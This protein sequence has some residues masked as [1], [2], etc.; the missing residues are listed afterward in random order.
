MDYERIGLAVAEMLDVGYT[1]EW[2]GYLMNIYGVPERYPRPNGS[3]SK[4]LFA[5]D[6]FR[7][8]AANEATRDIIVAIAD[9]IIQSERFDPRNKKAGERHLPVFKS[10]LER[11]GYRFP[12]DV[13]MR[14]VPYFRSRRFN[15]SSN[16]CFVIMP[17]TPDWSARVYSR[18]IR[19][20]LEGCGLEV[21][22][23]DD[24]FGH[25]IMEDIWRGINESLV[26]LADVTGRNANVFY[27]LGIA[28]TLGKRTIILTQDDRDVPFDI[29]RY[30]YIRYADNLDGYDLLQKQLPEHIRQARTPNAGQAR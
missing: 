21:I 30:R 27:E 14:V 18:V 2:I 15:L 24:M 10:I 28:H 9:Y 3:Q 12:E 7:Q 19:P 23:A 1:H 17:F 11:A 5:K 4:Y 29:A 6:L 8:L 26:V 13:G 25:D 22:R 20:I 16:R